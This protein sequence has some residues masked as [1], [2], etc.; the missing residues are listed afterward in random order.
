MAALLEFLPLLIFFVVYKMQDIFWATGALMAATLLQLLITYFMHKKIEKKQ[1]IFFAM[2]VAFG[3]LTLAFRDKTFIM[4]K[5]TAVY[6]LFAIVLLGSLIMKKPIME[7]M[8]G[9][10]VSLPHAVWVRITAAWG[11]FFIGAAIAN[12]YVAH[13]MSEDDWVNFKV[14]WMTGFSM[15]F[16]ILTIAYL[17][18]YLPQDEVKPADTAKDDN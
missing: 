7:Q 12:V 9:E 4:W 1:W 17:Y 18:R 5:P 2:V 11:L 16:M 13:H 3:A 15:G 6:A 14:F 8:M 10:V